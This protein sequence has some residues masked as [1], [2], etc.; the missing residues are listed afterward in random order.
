[1]VSMLSPGQIPDEIPTLANPRDEEWVENLN[2]RLVCPDCREDPPNLTEEMS[3]GDVVCL[4]CG[5]V[6]GDRL[7]DN[8]S[9]WRTFAND[10]V[11]GDDPSRV[12]KATNPLEAGHELETAISFGDGNMRSRELNRAHAKMNQ[13]KGRKSTSEGY[14]RIAQISDQLGVNEPACDYAKHLYKLTNNEK[15]FKGK[16]AEAIN[17]G[18]V[19]IACR[20]LNTPRSFRDVNAVTRVSKKDIGRTFKMLEKFL[21]HHKHSRMTATPGSGSLKEVGDGFED[22][23]ATSAA[24][25][26]IGYASQLLLDP[27]T[28]SISKS[29][30]ERLNL[31][32]GLAGRSPLSVAAACIYMGTHLMGTPKMPKEIGKIAGVSDGTIRT[33]YKLL[34]PQRERIIDPG[35]LVKKPEHKQGDPIG[36]MKRLPPV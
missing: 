21:R 13:D 26:V 25:L 16:N 34:W 30:A 11:G 29:I 19:F 33:A 22:K 28:I 32:G 20:Q 8:R 1:M 24:D 4:S 7:V 10:D 36:D 9:E 14:A 17:A 31:V 18:C 12:G 5:L 3:Q 23:Q 27:K 15:L 35:W 2:I 6:V